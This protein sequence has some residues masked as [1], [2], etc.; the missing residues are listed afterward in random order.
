M[1]RVGPGLTRQRQRLV[2]SMERACMR[3]IQ[4]RGFEEE[5]RGRGV[6]DKG[7]PPRRPWFTC[8]PLVQRIVLFLPSL[9]NGHGRISLPLR[10]GGAGHQA[11]RRS[12][13]GLDLGSSP[14]RGLRPRLGSRPLEEALLGLAGWRR[15]LLRPPKPVSCGRQP[16]RRGPHIEPPVGG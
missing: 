1:R 10:R 4:A 16:V 6:V 2:S 8:R 13:A 5:P 9:K 11:C 12:S 14:R 7:A 3:W 15:L